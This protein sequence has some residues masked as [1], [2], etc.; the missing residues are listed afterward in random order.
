MRAQNVMDN[1]IYRREIP[2][3][4]GVFINPGRRPD[5]PEPTPQELG[6]SRHE[7]ADRIQHARRQVRAGDH[8]RTAAGA[9]QGLQHLEGSRSGTGS[10][11]SSSGRDRRVHRGLGAPE[12]FPQ[13]AEQRRQLH[14][15]SRRTR[16]SRQ[17]SQERE[18]AD[19]R[20][21]AWTAGTTTAASARRKLR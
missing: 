13:G 15:Y 3:M 8:R 4:I 21:P 17:C 6:R 11:A 1:L 14:Q 7:P 9:L 18:E 12:P 2:V 5:Q 19:S 20:F 10:A 16:L